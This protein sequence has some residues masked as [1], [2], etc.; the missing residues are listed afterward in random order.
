[1][2][3]DVAGAQINWHWAWACCNG[4]GGPIISCFLLGR[5]NPRHWPMLTFQ[6]SHVSITIWFISFIFAIPFHFFIAAE[7]REIKDGTARERSSGGLGSL[8][9]DAGKV[10]PGFLGR[11]RRRQDG[12]QRTK[13]RR[14]R[15]L[16]EDDA[17]VGSQR[18]R[19]GFM[20]S[21]D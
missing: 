5:P 11:E 9:S 17:G 7:T 20:S 15:V 8:S 4:L 6:H 12:Q 10:W 21:M 18:R 3:L 16:A 1:M 13:R 19:R 2:H 14:R